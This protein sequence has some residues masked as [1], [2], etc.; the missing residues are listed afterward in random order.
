MEPVQSKSAAQESE[1]KNP[2]GELALI[3]RLAAELGCA[4]IEAAGGRVPFG[5]DM[6]ELSTDGKL[7]WT[8]DMLMEGVDFDSRVHTWRAI[9]R[10]AMAV[11]LS[12]CAAMAA[13][14]VA[15]LCAVALNNA[16]SMEEAL[17]LIR[18]VRDG[19][20]E[21]GCELRGGDTNSWNEPTVIAVT[22]AGRMDSGRAPVRRD[23]ARAGDAVYLTGPVGGSILA[24]HMTF[25]PRLD[26]ARRM[27]SELPV[28]A[29]VDVSDGVVLDL[30][31]VCQASGCGAVLD[32]Q[33]VERAIHEDAHRLSQTTGQPSIDHALYDGEDYELIVAL[34]AGVDPAKCSE[35]GLLQIG[36]FVPGDELAMRGVDGRRRRLE[37]RG[38]E[39]FR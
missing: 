38:W 14:P 22:V 23:G 34:G 16:L 32:E 5:D 3:R 20:L 33:L 31:R 9:G 27:V 17:E 15:A 37:V 7:L 13:T 2:K 29:M 25:C 39:H 10:K 26:V 35:V 18:G 12:D 8:T 24:R 28:R 19:G 1:V 36:E 11:N 6:A 30:W 4:G 21:F